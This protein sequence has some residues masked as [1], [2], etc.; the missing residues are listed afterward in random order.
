[1]LRNLFYFLLL[2]GFF[3]YLFTPIVHDSHVIMLWATYNNEDFEKDTLNNRIK[4]ATSFFCITK[5]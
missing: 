1:M 3:N 5:R 4:Y 2:K